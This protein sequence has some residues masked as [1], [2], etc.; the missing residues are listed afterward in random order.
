MLIQL[1]CLISSPLNQLPAQSSNTA[2]WHSPILVNSCLIFFFFFSSFFRGSSS[3]YKKATQMIILAKIKLRLQTFLSIVTHLLIINFEMVWDEIIT[4]EKMKQKLLFCSKLSVLH[5]I[6]QNIFWNTNFKTSRET[7]FVLKKKTLIFFIENA[8]NVKTA[9]CLPSVMFFF[10]VFNVSYWSVFLFL[11]PHKNNQVWNKLIVFVVFYVCLCLWA[12]RSRM[13]LLKLVG[14]WRSCR[15]GL[16][17]AD[18]WYQPRCNKVLFHC[19]RFFAHAE[20]FFVEMLACPE[21]FYFC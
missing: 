9:L 8:K 11:T 7:F 13:H 10:F 4:T 6:Y 21:N 14:E 15:G 17:A 19:R 3:Q 20:D 12:K 2:Q 1:A 18:N 16:A 5:T